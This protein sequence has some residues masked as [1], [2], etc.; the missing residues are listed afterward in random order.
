VVEGGARGPAA[1]RALRGSELDTGTRR[2]EW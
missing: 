2:N 1:S